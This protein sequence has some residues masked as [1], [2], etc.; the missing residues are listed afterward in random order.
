METIFAVSAIGTLIF[1]FIKT[2]IYFIKG[3]VKWKWK[4]PFIFKVE[5]LKDTVPKSEKKFQKKYQGLDIPLRLLSYIW[6]YP[7][8]GD[9]QKSWAVKE[10]AILK[11]DLVSACKMPGLGIAIFSTE[12]ALKAFGEFS[13]K[14]YSQKNNIRQLCMF[15][16]LISC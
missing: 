15:R 10:S 6:E 5:S 13:G 4:P 12:L 1:A 16:L 8:L 3:E 11:G 9:P 14:C 7:T 2:T